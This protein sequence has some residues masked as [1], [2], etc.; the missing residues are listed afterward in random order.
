MTQKLY[1][2]V[3]VFDNCLFVITLVH[4]HVGHQFQKG[5]VF[6]ILVKNEDL[7]YKFKLCNVVSC[8]HALFERGW[9][10]NSI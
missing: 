7:S 1:K 6:F 3:L 10:E 2:T 5:Q 9:R 4:D 8:C